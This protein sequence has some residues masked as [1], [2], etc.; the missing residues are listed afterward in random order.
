[1]NRRVFAYSGNIPEK[2]II[3]L[4]ISA[5]LTFALAVFLTVFLTMTGNNKV[6]VPFSAVLFS[7]FALQLLA[8]IMTLLVKRRMKRRQKECLYSDKP[9]FL[10]LS[11]ASLGKKDFNVHEISDVRL[12]FQSKVPDNRKR[13]VSVCFFLAKEDKNVKVTE[14]F[15]LMDRDQMNDFRSFLQANNVPNIRF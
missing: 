15:L 8:L 4:I 10:H 13:I 14:G 3:A 5:I 7:L 2:N 12:S 9:S 6:M 1:M 11:S